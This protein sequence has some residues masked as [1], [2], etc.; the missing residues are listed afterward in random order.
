MNLKPHPDHTQ[1][2]ADFLAY[3]ADLKGR[4]ALLAADFFSGAGGLSFGLEKPAS[5]S[6]SRQN[7]EFANRTHAHHFGGMAVDWDLSDPR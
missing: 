1:D 3:A 5:R 2:E 4:G 6:C 7:H